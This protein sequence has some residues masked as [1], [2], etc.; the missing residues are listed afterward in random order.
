MANYFQSMKTEPAWLRPPMFDRNNATWF[1]DVDIIYLSILEM[2]TKSFNA[3]EITA[4]ALNLLHYHALFIIGLFCITL[5]FSPVM[6]ITLFTY[7]DDA[8]SRQ[9]CFWI[10]NSFLLQISNYK[11]I[12]VVVHIFANFMRLYFFHC[13]LISFHKFNLLIYRPS[14]AYIM[15]MKRNKQRRWR[16][17]E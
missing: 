2:M 3:N 9:S 7:D 15:K 4:K 16:N 8:S 17:F 14:A 1:Q 12:P 11:F 5:L 6:L 10:V 13:I